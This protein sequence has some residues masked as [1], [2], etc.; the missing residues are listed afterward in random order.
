MIKVLFVCAGNIC[1]SPMAEALLQHE[2]QQAG[3]EDAILVDSAGTGNWHVGEGAHRGTLELL[4]KQGI[5]YHG[6]ARQL[7]QRD[8]SDFDY[9][10]AMD[11]QNLDHIK[12]HTGGASDGEI[13]LFLSYANDAGLTKTTEV[14]DPY[15][16]GRYQEVYDLAEIGVRALLDHIRK[17]H[18]L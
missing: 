5:D 12:R 16:N 3:L 2:V 13:R 17:K 15:Y 11:K 1:R 4:K 8:F 18:N 6:R 14:P 10:L 9:I 7:T